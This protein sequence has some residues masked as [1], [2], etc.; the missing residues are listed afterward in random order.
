[1]ARNEIKTGSYSFQGSGE[2]KSYRKKAFAIFCCCL[3]VTLQI[4]GQYIAY[5]YMHHPA[6]GWRVHCSG[7]RRI[8]S[9]GPR[10]GFSS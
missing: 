8:R 1:M 4:T 10:T 5:Q 6:L 7:I 2:D 3:A 9:T